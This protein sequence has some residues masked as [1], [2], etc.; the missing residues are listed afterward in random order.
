M[1]NIS[2]A[3]HKNDIT[4]PSAIESERIVLGAILADDDALFKSVLATGLSVDD[5]TCSAHRSIYLAMLELHQDGCP[6]DQVSVADRMGDKGQAYALMVDIMAGAVV[7]KGHV[8]Y[9]ANLIRQKA[10]LREML[11]IA[12]WISETAVQPAQD[13]QCLA[14]EVLERV[15][16]VGQ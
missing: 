12:E 14:A 8:V 13:P 2:Q 1:P 4:L 3:G 5:Y 11:K 6:I 16:A 10:R 15:R 7:H 9:H